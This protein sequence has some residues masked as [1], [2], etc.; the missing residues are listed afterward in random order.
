MA[1]VTVA[2]VNMALRLGLDIEA[3]AGTQRYDDIVMKIDQ[4]QDIVLDYVTVAEKEDWTSDT[5]P[6][7][8]QAA[9][10]LTVRC[11]LDDSE[12]SAAWLSGLG[13]GMNDDVRNPIV[14]LLRRL[15]DPALA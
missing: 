14:A 3:G 11:L 15:R 6:D 12:E 4:A 13:N 7:R 5:L 2:Q 8:V 1:F 9:I 10:I